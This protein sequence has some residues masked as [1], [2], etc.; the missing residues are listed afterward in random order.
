MYVDTVFGIKWR[1]ALAP[2]D[3][4]LIL[5]IVVLSLTIYILYKYNLKVKEEALK[6]NLLFQFKIKKYGLTGLQRR[7]IN[8]IVELQKLKDMQ[9]IFIRPDLF[10]AS[11]GDILTYMKDV[12]EDKNSLVNVCKDLIITYEKL[13][14]HTEVRKPID[15]ISDIGPGVLLYFYLDPSVVYVG[16]LLHNDDAKMNLQVFR[17]RSELPEIKVGET[18]NFYFWRA[19]DAEYIFNSEVILYELGQVT[20]KTPSEFT[21]GKEVRR[22]YVDVL[23]QCSLIVTDPLYH[24][25]TLEEPKSIPSTILKMNEHEVVMRQTEKLDFKYNY[26]IN[27][28]IDEFK[29]IAI[30]KVI[31]DKTIVEGNVH[32]YTCKIEEISEA[33]KEIL[34][35][36][37]R[38]SY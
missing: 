15:R 19:G 26:T 27:F 20:I 16:K 2:L 14:H 12:S 25:A 36:Y 35:K 6:A 17:S 11:I 1:D 30:V 5:I 23:L 9:I 38:E 24:S 31:A 4:I 28:E 13:Y 10:E 34:H 33:A 21:R 22:P 7:I 3:V 18:Y 8:H 32:Y 37:L 29:V